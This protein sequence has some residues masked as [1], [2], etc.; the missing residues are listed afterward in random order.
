MSLN[1]LKKKSQAKYNNS[2]VG[3][4]QFSLNG[5]TRN[6][7]YVGQDVLGRSLIKTPMVGSIARGYGGCCGAYLQS[8]VQP[9][10]IQYQ[11]NSGTV[12]PSVLSNYGSIRTHYRWAWRGAP[13]T[14][15]KPDCN[16]TLNHSQG[17]YLERLDQKT[18]N[19]INTC[20]PSVGHTYDRS[21][22]CAAVPYKNYQIKPTCLGTIKDVGPLTQSAHLQQVKSGCTANDA[23]VPVAVNRTPF[24]GMN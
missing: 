17:S 24:R 3:Y 14:S 21:L 5:T 23:N 22:Q 11:N 18:I 16:F 19:E 2:S 9:S 10:G 20:N 12:K 4:R 8:T 1:T 6:Q 15:V 13:Y 7:G